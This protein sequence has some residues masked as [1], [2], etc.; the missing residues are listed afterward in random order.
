MGSEMC[1]RDSD[2]TEYIVIGQ[3]TQTKLITSPQ[4]ITIGNSVIEASQS[5]KNIG[6]VL[7]NKLDMKDHVNY[8]A[9][10][11]YFL[12]SYTNQDPSKY[13]NVQ[14]HWFMHLYRQSLTA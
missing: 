13:Q 5:V 3:P 10:S 9:R 2:K 14:Q 6:A 11:C 8:V 7:D 1:I 12:S 4:T